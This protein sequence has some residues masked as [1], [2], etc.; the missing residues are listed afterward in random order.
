MRDADADPCSGS[1]RRDENGGALVKDRTTTKPAARFPVSA[2]R[3][4]GS[5]AGRSNWKWQVL[6]AAATA[7]L[8]L[9]FAW[10]IVSI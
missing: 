3:H 4:A 8:F 5:K 6:D 10:V 1:A 9:L 7:A 2:I